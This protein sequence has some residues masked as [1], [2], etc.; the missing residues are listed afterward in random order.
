MAWKLVTL[1]ATIIQWFELWVIYKLMII[2]SL[3]EPMSDLQL[4]V[5]VWMLVGTGACTL[6]M[7]DMLRKKTNAKPNTRAAAVGWKRSL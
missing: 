6:L 2:Q 3:Y 7:V 5:F 4:I 1:V